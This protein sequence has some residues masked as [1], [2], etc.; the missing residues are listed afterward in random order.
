MKT[1]WE[2]T[3]EYEYADIHCH[4]L[5]GIDD[6]AR[7]MAESEAMLSEARRN[8]IRR[9]VATPHVKRSD[10]NFELAQKRFEELKAFADKEGIELRL[11]F[12]V[13]CAALIEFGFE[14]LDMLSFQD[15][16][17][18]LL[19]FE[20]FSL[21]PNWEIIIRKICEAGKKVIIA[22]PERYHF[23]QR[24]IKLARKMVDMDCR[25]QCDAYVFDLNRFSREKRIADKMVNEGL[26]SWIATDAHTKKHY[27]GYKEVMEDYIYDLRIGKISFKRKDNR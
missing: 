11:G 8:G 20:P 23:I 14:N 13:N 27:E 7:S 26:V 16:D 17:Y 4:I 5:P 9:I 22:H 24:N 6:G 1:V 2:S 25:L 21:P 15:S 10:F 3:N 19:E 18:F 12:E